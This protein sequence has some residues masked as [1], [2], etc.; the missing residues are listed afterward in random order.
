[1]KKTTLKRIRNRTIRSHWKLN[2]M[3]TVAY[4]KIVAMVSTNLEDESEQNTSDHTNFKHHYLFVS[5]KVL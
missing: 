2:P 3:I 4:L 1:M 5:M